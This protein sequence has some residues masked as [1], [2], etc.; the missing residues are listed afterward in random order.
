MAQ[1]VCIDGTDFQVIDG[2]ITLLPHALRSATANFTH[3]LDG[4]NGTF[5]EITE[6]APLVI[7]A[8]AGGKW[9]VAWDV[10]G[11]ATNTASTPP[12]AVSTNVYAALAKNNVV[13][14]GTET[15]VLVNNQGITTNAQP[16]YQLHAT[17][18]GTDILDLVPGDEL[19]LFAARSSDAG[20]T[21]QVLSNPT[22]RTRIR[23]WRIGP[24]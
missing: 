8:G 10:H 18:S 17:G 16:S 21:T 23:A 11:E 22:G 19:S 3:L 7:P 13:V 1:P 2:K 4:A 20:T 12:T 15:E 6:I 9:V 24:S 5:E 14:V